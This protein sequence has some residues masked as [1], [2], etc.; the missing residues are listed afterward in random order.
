[1]SG[2]R[3]HLS[4]GHETM[5]TPLTMRLAMNLLLNIDAA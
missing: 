5:A 2:K 4:D 3:E 1:M